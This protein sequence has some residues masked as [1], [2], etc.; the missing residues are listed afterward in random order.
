MNDLTVY[1]ELYAIVCQGDLSNQLDARLKVLP[2]VDKALEHVYQR[3]NQQK[4]LLIVAALHGHELVARILLS[5]SSNVRNLVKITGNTYDIKGKRALLVTAL[6]C[7]CD[8]GHYKL[9]Q[10]LID[11]GQACIDDSSRNPLLIEAINNERL[12]TIQFLIENDHVDINETTEYEYRKYN[13]LMFA[14]ALGQTQI[15]AYL[16]EKGAKVDY[17]GGVNSGTALGCAALHGHLEVVKILCSAGACPNIKNRHGETPMILAYKNG[18]FDVAEYLLDLTQNDLYIDELELIACSFIIPPRNN[19][20]DPSPFVKM[21]NLMRKSF[22]IR[23]ARYCPKIIMKPV[24]A[25]NFETECQTLKEFDKIQDDHDRL[26]IEALLI[27]ERILLP[28]KLKG[29]CEPLLMF[30]EKLIEKGDYESCIRLWEHTFYLYQLMNHETSLH[31]FVWIFCKMLATHVS[32]SPQLFLQICR[33]TSEP[34]QK[35]NA[36]H[37]I[38]N[39]VC[40]VT[41]AAKILDQEKLTKAERLSIYEWISDICREKRTTPYRQTLLHLSVNEQTHLDINYR[42]SEIR[43]ILSFPNLVTTQ[44]LLTHGSRW[45]NCDAVDILNGDTALHIVSQSNKPEALSIVKLLLNAGAHIDCRNKHNK[46]P[47]D[48]A[49]TIEMKNLL[50]RQQASVS[51]KCLCACYIVEKQINYEFIWRKD[52]KLNT[53]IYLHDCI[54][55][56]NI[57]SLDSKE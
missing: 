47:F 36:S 2:D 34:S 38:K 45:I 20:N 4:T 21:V 25:Y 55:K 54:A 28:K 37:Y 29:L 7:A 41:I 18:Q 22:K 1:D 31:R 44:L 17:L 30:G 9:A 6:W 52:T 53:F 50:Q 56:Q 43:Q 46:T 51:L 32:I 5:H 8:R 48:S 40:L 57:T 49:K 15:V 24:T 26:F 14:A 42:A 19:D 33:L 39:T 12:D 13:S 23:E 10:T 35:Q 11:V 3:D 16:V 27:R